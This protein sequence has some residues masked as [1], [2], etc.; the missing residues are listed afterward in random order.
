M[1]KMRRSDFSKWLRSH[2]TLSVCMSAQSCLT[3][4]DPIDCSPEGSSVHG[5][6]Q[7]GILEQ[8]VN[9]FRGSSLTSLFHQ[10]GASWWQVQAE[11]AV[12]S[13]GN[14]GL[15]AESGNWLTIHPRGRMQNIREGCQFLEHQQILHTLVLRDVRRAR[16]WEEPMWFLPG[17]GAGTGVSGGDHKG[18]V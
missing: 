12:C 15:Q 6:L 10:T 7:A 18:V 2:I 9:S 3:L 4:R 1:S 16:K 11:L 14:I 17:G 8:A 13:W 5:D